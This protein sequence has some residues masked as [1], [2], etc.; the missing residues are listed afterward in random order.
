MNLAINITNNP[1]GGALT[2]VLNMLNYFNKIDDLNIII[3]VK[4]E[5]LELINDSIINNNRIFVSSISGFSVPFRII[6]EQIFLPFYLFLHKVDI[7]FCPGNTAPFFSPIITVQW[8]GTI[9]P[10]WDKIYSYDI[11]W[12]TKF[13]LLCNKFVMY[14]SA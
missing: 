14:K 2:Q 10:F 3:Y 11:D 12:Y 5:N 7:L 6:W 8:I 9:G 1:T 4:R 13:K